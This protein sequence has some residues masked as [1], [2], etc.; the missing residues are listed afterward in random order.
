MA[1][2]IKNVHQQMS[3]ALQEMITDDIK[4]KMTEA[5]ESFGEIKSSANGIIDPEHF[6]RIQCNITG[7]V[8]EITFSAMEKHKTE[9]RELLKNS[10]EQQ[11]Q[12]CIAKF[13]Q[14]QRGVNQ[15]LTDSYV[16]QAAIEPKLFN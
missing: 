5:I 14:T 8:Q 9:R 3:K 15:Q 12:E 2:G 11:Y 7:L 4:K 16:K 6:Y 10:K 13:A 1:E